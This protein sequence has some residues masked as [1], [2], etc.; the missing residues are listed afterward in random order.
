MRANKRL[1]LILLLFLLDKSRSLDL[2]ALEEVESFA[3]LDI[4]H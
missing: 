4:N 2:P 1:M 3:A